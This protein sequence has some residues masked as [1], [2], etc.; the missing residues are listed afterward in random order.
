MKK[1]PIYGNLEKKGEREVDGGVGEARSKAAK[2][3]HYPLQL[4]VEK[5]NHRSP[6]LLGAELLSTYP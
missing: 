5:Q 2:C 1:F 6:F 4:L 3:L